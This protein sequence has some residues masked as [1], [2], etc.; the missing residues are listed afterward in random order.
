MGV[1]KG[2]SAAKVVEAILVEHTADFESA[3]RR[4]LRGG[5][6]AFHVG[7]DVFS[8]GHRVDLEAGVAEKL[9]QLAQ[10]QGAHVREVAQGFPAILIR[11]L[12]GMLAGKNVFH[13]H[14]TAGMA[15]GRHLAEDL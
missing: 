8:R 4:S 1:E 14:S 5:E 11:S 6:P 10:R 7:R 2:P 3:V 13:E 9:K 12:L 15:S